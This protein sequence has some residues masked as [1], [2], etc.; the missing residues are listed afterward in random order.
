P[1]PLGI[2]PAGTAN[3]LGMELGLGGGLESVVKR[4]AGFVERRVALGRVS[5]GNGLQRHFLA[6]GGVGLDAR[7]VYDL[8]PAWKARAGKAAYWTTGFAHVGQSVAQFDA[9]VNGK[10]YRCGFALASR[11]RN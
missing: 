8:N 1:V 4:L 2:L 7:I 6:M 5:N 10:V 3:V 11:V 9:T